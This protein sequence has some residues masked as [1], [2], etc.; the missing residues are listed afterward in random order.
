M[1]SSHRSKWRKVPVTQNNN[2]KE[3]LLHDL[4]WACA[5]SILAMLFVWSAFCFA[6]Q[7][8]E[9][10][11]IQPVLLGFTGAFVFVGNLMDG[12]CRRTCRRR[13]MRHI[14]HLVLFGIIAFG[15]IRGVIG[16]EEQLYQGYLYV[17]GRI[18]E[19]V[20]A[21]YK[22]SFSVPVGEAGYANLFVN[23]V[24]AAIILVLGTI[25]AERRKSIWIGVFPAVILIGDLC[26]GASPEYAGLLVFMTG[27][28]LSVSPWWK[29]RQKIGLSVLLIG[30]LCAS[31]GISALGF[32]NIALQIAAKKDEMLK[33]QKELEKDVVSAFSSI[34]DI[35][36]IRISNDYPEYKNKEVL[37]VET[38]KKPDKDFY[39]RGTYA[40]TYQNG[41]WKQAVDFDIDQS[42]FAQ[43]EDCQD[44]DPS[45]AV[46]NEGFLASQQ[47]IY[48]DSEGERNHYTVKYT[49]LRTEVLYLPYLS[50][51]DSLSGKYEIE[52]DY[53]YRKKRRENTITVQ[54]IN[55]TA[56]FQAY[57]TRSVLYYAE[58]PEYQEFYDYYNAYVMENYLDVP[59]Q[60]TAVKSMASMINKSNPDI[61]MNSNS[62]M[63]NLDRIRVAG[64]VRQLLTDS[65]SYQ[66]NLPDAGSMDKVEFFLEK[67]QGGFC[68]HFASAGVLILR[69]LGVPARYV[70]GYYVD[71]DNFT[72]ND[73]GGFTCSVKDS[74]AHAWTE[75]YL[76]NYGWIAVD[77]TPG[78]GKYE[79]GELKE[80][81]DL[82]NKETVQS[83]EQ[84]AAEPAEREEQNTKEQDG[85]NQSAENDTDTAAGSDQSSR[86]SN[87]TG[88][89]KSDSVTEAG[90]SL[91]WKI[92]FTLAAGAAAVSSV[93]ISR[94]RKKERWELVLKRA[95]RNGRYSKAAK[96]INQRLYL[97]LLRSQ[98]MPKKNLSNQEYL[99]LLQQVYPEEDWETYMKTMR[100]AVYSAEELEP[101]EFSYIYEQKK[102]IQGQKAGN[103]RTL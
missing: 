14:L 90:R 23:T 10:C 59:E 36:S 99:I 88:D 22:I 72:A 48:G 94:K 18:L 44:L 5:N 69:E 62:D 3:T 61:V 4:F 64:L 56:L 96:L 40:D 80:E 73:N 41:V 15:I 67:G 68:V 87:T 42:D 97:H 12:V 26:I 19:R 24:A 101:E 81:A 52:G 82:T 25:A 95:I 63:I 7:R 98:K 20:N 74:D 35:Q 2:Q 100:K 50:D 55:E 51:A 13:W 54:A 75:I 34:S 39:L 77:M 57:M 49:N 37:R 46:A 103:S 70:S 21:Y 11:E 65:F 47:E 6:K 76:E 85:N 91:N 53:Q 78:Y 102:I 8:L 45:A 93:C 86:G 43:Y 58:L 9:F 28:I 27:I 79:G 17:T 84:N 31:F 83:E 89:E 1:C 66:T 30:I 60:M 29:S 38:D 71:S 33:I 32:S 92:L 16:N